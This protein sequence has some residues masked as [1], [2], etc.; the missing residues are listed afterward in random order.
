ML[1]PEGRFS[2]SEEL[3]AAESLNYSIV[4]VYFALNGE[5]ELCTS[6]DCCLLEQ[7]NVPLCRL[8]SVV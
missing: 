2:G 5:L 8:T 3:H 6:S 7:E 1:P 4:V